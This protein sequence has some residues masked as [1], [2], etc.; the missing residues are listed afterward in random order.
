MAQRGHV[1]IAE[2]VYVDKEADGCLRAFRAGIERDYALS[3]FSWGDEIPMPV[4]EAFEP[5]SP[6]LMHIRDALLA[7][8]AAKELGITDAHMFYV[9]SAPVKMPVIEIDHPLILPLGG[10]AQK[11]FVY[12][13]NENEDGS[14]CFKIHGL[15]YGLSSG[16]VESL[17]LTKGKD[18]S[19]IVNGSINA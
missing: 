9:N 16:Y 12:V 6:A 18:G 19:I 14:D 13:E 8:P 3:D 17:T 15:N 4:V 5:P 11:L 1:G 7:T 10:I 2:P